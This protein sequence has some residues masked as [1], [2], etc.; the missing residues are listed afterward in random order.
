MTH[1]VQ[2]L[3]LVVAGWVNRQQQDVV[4]YL[5]EENRILRSQLKGKRLR[6]TDRDRR[7]LAVKAKASGSK[8]L[9][10]VASIATPD[11]I[12]RWYRQLVAAKY[13][14]SKKRGSGRPR[15]AADIAK[16]VVTMATSNPTWGYT[17]LRGALAL[18]GINLGRSTIKRILAAHGIEP[19]PE[20]GKRTSWRTFIRSHL[21]E[22]AA[23]DLFT[24]EV[25]H[26]FGLT[27]YHVMFVIDIATRR[28]CIGG[29]TSDPSGEW[30]KTVMRGMTDCF[31]GFLVGKRYLIHDRDPLFTDSVRGW[32][33]WCGVEPLRLP[34][35]SP[36]LNAY[37]ERFVLSVRAE[38]LSR[39]IPL[40]EGHLRRII[41]EFVTHY[42]EERPHQGLGNQLIAPVPTA[43][44]SDG[45][46]KCRERVGGVLKYYY[47]DAA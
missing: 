39:I 6:L 37:A 11:T 30:M 19:A 20:R 44:N 13:D 16:L 1:H 27:R 38:Y 33:R 28:V 2:L 17:R 7:R 46:I 26:P 5:Q 22:I 31:D 14:G 24:V 21:G 42:H 18:L 15:T 8:A 29:I 40:S 32:L 35:H 41:S 36:N 25:L 34:A 3:M 9:Q 43:A 10:R 45:P 12:L 47:R 23:T 4:D